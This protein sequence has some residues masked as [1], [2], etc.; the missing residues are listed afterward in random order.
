MQIIMEKIAPF[1]GKNRGFGLEI[2]TI[3]VYN[4]KSKKGLEK[5]SKLRYSSFRLII[6]HLGRRCKAAWE[7]SFFVWNT[8][9]K[10]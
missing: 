1:M 3:F 7:R 9:R 5:R 2:Y 10:K 4:L 6:T 8:I